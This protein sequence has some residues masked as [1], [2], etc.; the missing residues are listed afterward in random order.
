MESGQSKKTRTLEVRTVFE[1]SRVAQSCMAHAYERMV[2]AVY[3]GINV[4]HDG[5]QQGSSND[6]T[7]GAAR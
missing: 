7:S 1:P 6:E 5:E 3:R 4:R 2:P